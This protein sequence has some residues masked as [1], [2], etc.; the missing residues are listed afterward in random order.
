MRI[1]I[2]GASSTGKTTLATMLAQRLGVSVAAEGAR[3][4]ARAVGIVDSNEVSVANAL[5]FQRLVLEIKIQ[6]ERK[7][8]SRYVSDRTVVDCA[9]FW[10]YRELRGLLQASVSTRENYFSIVETYLRSGPYDVL[11]FLEHG[12]FTWVDDGFRIEDQEFM[13][14]LLLGLLYGKFRRVLESTG[15]STVIVPWEIRTPESRVA[16]CLE[17]IERTVR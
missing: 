6:V 2:T 9:A 1:G 13:S 5:E 17:H 7:L 15:T 14:A 10:L 4:A 11:L 8:H 12:A 16:F 3:E